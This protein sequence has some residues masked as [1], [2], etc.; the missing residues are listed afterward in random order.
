MNHGFTVMALRLSSS[1]RSGTH[2]THRC[3]KKTRQSS[4]PC[5]VHVDRFTSTFNGL[6]S[7]NSNPLF[8]TISGKFYCELLKWLREAIRPKRPE[9]YKNNTWF[10]HHD[11]A[12]AHTSLHGLT[13]SNFPKHKYFTPSFSWPC[14]LWFY[15]T[16]SDEITPEWVRFNS[17]KKIQAE[18][19][20]VLN[21]LTYET[22]QEHME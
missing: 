16:S 10:L 9:K 12:P 4:Q 22:F 7:S 6:Y 11:N 2:Q 18:T 3:R 1:C 8:I 17:I 19:Q 21:A 13:H 20:K 5:Q 15:P 14:F